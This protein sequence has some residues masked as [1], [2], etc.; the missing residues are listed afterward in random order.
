MDTR[1]FYSWTTSYYLSN[2]NNSLFVEPARLCSSTSSAFGPQLTIG[3]AGV[4][5]FF[6]IQA[7]DEYL[8]NRKGPDNGLTPKHWS[9]AQKVVDGYISEVNGPS[10]VKLE[11]GTNN[12]VSTIPDAYK[13]KRI[14]LH[15]LDWDAEIT[16]HASSGDITVSPSFP[17]NPPL[18]S[19]FTVYDGEALDDLGTS[20]E[21]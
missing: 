17:Y 20:P 4:Q 8:N 6:T 3:T 15:D 10:A 21:M 14:H 7:R 2:S 18:G 5:S 9:L 19:N 16:S 13:H 12:V 1:S 11:A